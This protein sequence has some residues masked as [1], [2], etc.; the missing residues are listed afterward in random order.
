M[1]ADFWAWHGCCPH[2]LT[3]AMAP[4]LTLSQY[5]VCEI[6]SADGRGA[7]GVPPLVGSYWQL[8]VAERDR[9]TVFGAVEPGRLLTL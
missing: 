5:Q 9:V 8:T 4:C 3:V 7:H 1:T 2:Q 6:S